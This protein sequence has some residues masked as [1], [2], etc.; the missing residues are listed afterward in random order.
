MERIFNTWL[1][2]A[3]LGVALFYVFRDPKFTGSF[4]TQAGQTGGDFVATLQ[5]R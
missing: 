2:L 5:G 1:G 4:L 3:G